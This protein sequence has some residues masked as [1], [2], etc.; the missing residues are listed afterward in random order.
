[1]HERVLGFDFGTKRIGMA[2][3]NRLTARA[4]PIGALPAKDGIPN[5]EQLADILEQWLP[6][7]L[8]IGIPLNIDGSEQTVTRLAR[9]FANRLSA[10]YQLPIYHVDERLSTKEAR[11]RMFDA[12]GYK[13]LQS[14][15]IDSIAAQI[16]VEQWLMSE[17][18]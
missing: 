5:W 1:M 18:D 17:G 3:G 13:K 15:Q 9:K 4:E 14:T 16:I 10:R 6:D 7:A 2:V 11:Q 12:G 8:V